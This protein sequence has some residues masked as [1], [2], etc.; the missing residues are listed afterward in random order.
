MVAGF[1]SDKHKKFI[2][3][4]RKIVEKQ[5]KKKKQVKEKGDDKGQE[6]SK[7]RYKPRWIAMIVNSHA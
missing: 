7:K 5:K 4:I 6:D 1:V 3:H 2:A